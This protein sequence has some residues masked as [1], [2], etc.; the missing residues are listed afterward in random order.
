MNLKN[1]FKKKP[2]LN[3][4]KNQPC[5]DKYGRFLGWYS[6]SSASVML[7]FCKDNTEEWCVLSCE[8]GPG[9]GDYIGYWNVPCG[10]LDFGE[11][12]RQCA[13]RECL[14]ETGILLKGGD[15]TFIGYEDDPLTANRQNVSFRYAALLREK[16][17]DD[18]TFSKI[19]NEND[20]VGEIKW[21][22]V[23]DIFKYNWAFGHDKL[24]ME[25]FNYNLASAKV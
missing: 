10:Y 20:E 6:R 16:K 9:A 25:V 23:K 18:F 13:I 15:V 21:I 12:T 11:T 2:K 5:Y 14:E 22:R 7:V 19:L 24:I 17:T 3:R 1:L 4:H 8:R